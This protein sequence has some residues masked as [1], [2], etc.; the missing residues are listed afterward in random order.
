[1]QR[2]TFAGLDRLDP[3]DPL[4]TDGGAFKG[5]NID[6]IDQWLSQIVAHRHNNAPAL[7]NPTQAAGISSQATGG[8]LPAATPIY[9]TYTYL[10]GSGGETAAAPIVTVTTPNSIG[11]PLPLASASLSFASGQLMVNTYQYVFTV[12]DAAGGESN[13]SAAL[14]IERDPGPASAQVLFSGLHGMVVNASGA[15]W[16]CY[17]AVGG[18]QYEFLATGTA[19]TFTDDGTVPV[20]YGTQPPASDTTNQTAQVTLVVPAPSGA[21]GGFNVYL[22]NTTTFADPSLFGTFSLASAGMPIVISGLQLNRGAPPPVSTAVRGAAQINPATDIFGWAALNINPFVVMA[23]GGVPQSFAS[24]AGAIPV[25]SGLVIE[26]SGGA[27]AF[28]GYINGSAVVRVT[29]GPPTLQNATGAV[30]GFTSGSGSNV[31]SASTF[32]GGIGTTAY[33]LGDIVAALKRDG[34]LAM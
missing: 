25:G 21:L 10:D 16:R 13:I 7:A 33:T 32:T 27:S 15:S 9:A 5:R 11:T 3:G 20:T 6:T 4:S 18:A 2:S 22:S 8:N 14:T 34:I 29:Q 19:D 23:S 1:M 28:V 30:A 17:K 26:A 12:T 31:L 24:A